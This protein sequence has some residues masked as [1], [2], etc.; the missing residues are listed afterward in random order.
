MNIIIKLILN[1]FTVMVAA[2]LV[3]GIVIADLLTGAIVAISLG[4]VN[5]FVK[6]II[7]LVSLP[8]TIL[9]LGLFSLVINGLMVLLVSALVPGFEVGGL[10]SAILFSLVASLIGAFLNNLT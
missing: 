3:P 4:V 6:P 10:L 2:Y 7:H 9:T 5:M 1:T 8:L